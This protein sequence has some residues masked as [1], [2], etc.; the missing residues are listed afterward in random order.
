M[1][2]PKLKQEI[3]EKVQAILKETCHDELSEGEINFLLHVD[4]AASWSWA[5]INNNGA[6]D[7]N[8]PGILFQNLSVI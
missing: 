3:S 4:G 1:F 7:F 8:V 5:N 6:S 2:S